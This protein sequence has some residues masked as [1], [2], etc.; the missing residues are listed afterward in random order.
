MLIKVKVCI[1][2]VLCLFWGNWE[3]IG[4][5]VF[6]LILIMLLVVIYGSFFWN[7]LI[8]LKNEIKRLKVSKIILVVLFLVDGL[9]V[10][11]LIILWGSFVEIDWLV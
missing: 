5:Y 8:F 2:N 7:F 6:F 3:G 11:K 4:V 10:E 9:F 1:C